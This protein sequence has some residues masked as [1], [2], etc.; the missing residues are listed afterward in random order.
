MTSPRSTN[1]ERRSRSRPPGCSPTRGLV[2]EAARTALT[3]HHRLGP[4]SSQRVVVEADLAFHRALVVGTGNARLTRAH[5][6]LEIEILLCLAQLVQGYAIGRPARRRAR[7]AARGHRSRRPARR[8]DGHP[9]PPRERHVV[10]GRARVGSRRRRSTR[11]A[12]PP[13]ARRATSGR[14]RRSAGWRGRSRRS[15]G[16]RPSGCCAPPRCAAAP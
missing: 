2:P 15:R 1:C 5:K 16:C 3:Q 4:R 13:P 7:R 14:P 9:A 8:R 10:A 11:L 12:A 6:N